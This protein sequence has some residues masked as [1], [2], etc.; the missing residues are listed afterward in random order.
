MHMG[1]RGSSRMHMAG[2]VS[3]WGFTYTYIL[4]HIPCIHPGSRF[5]EIPSRHLVPLSLRVILDNPDRDG[6][7]PLLG[8]H[9]GKFCLVPFLKI[10]QD[11]SGTPIPP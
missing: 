4:A 11:E 7:R 10:L 8:S 5:P 3:M 9:P 1:A 2:A 6:F